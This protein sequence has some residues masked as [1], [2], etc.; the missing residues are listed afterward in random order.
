[1]SYADLRTPQPLPH[2]SIDFN[3]TSVLTPLI[4]PRQGAGNLSPYESGVEYGE[5]KRLGLTAELDR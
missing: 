2:P 5:V 1:L 4:F 3:Y